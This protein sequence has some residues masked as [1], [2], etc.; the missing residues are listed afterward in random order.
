ME[1]KVGALLWGD[2]L[3]LT[4]NQE[5]AVMKILLEYNEVI[6]QLSAEEVQE[7][8]VTISASGEMD[9]KGKKQT[10]EE[11]VLMETFVMVHTHQRLEEI[12]GR[13][14][15]Y[16][17]LV[18][19]CIGAAL[20]HKKADEVLNPDGVDREGIRDLTGGKKEVMM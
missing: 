5:D 3:L 4:Q 11:L 19:R 2:L 12:R 9:K 8:L 20:G 13:T 14:I 16:F 6:P 1:L 7:I 17:F 15:Q 18:S 10:V